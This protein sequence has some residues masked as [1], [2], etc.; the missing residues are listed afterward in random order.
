MSAKGRSRYDITGQRFGKWQVIE[1]TGKVKFSSAVWLCKCDCGTVREVTSA[2]LRRGDTKSC[3]CG[4]PQYD[5][6]AHRTHGGKGTRLYVV[7]VGMRQRCENKNKI[8]YKYY[9]GRGIK[10]C[11]EWQ[12]FENFRE[13]A[14]A[15]G[16]DP[17]AERGVYT[18]ER[19]D[20]NGNYC[21]ENCTWVTIAEQ[22]K[23]KRKGSKQD[24][25]VG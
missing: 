22:M 8:N 20:V 16:Y 2:S 11:D 9:G 10:V 6:D 23:N 3:G 13:W 15:T 24:V 25:S 5:A 19:I 18:I 17:E 1:Y 4:K 7:W 14:Y 12:N 21:P